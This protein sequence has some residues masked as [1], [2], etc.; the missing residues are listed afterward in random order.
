[1]STEPFKVDIH[2]HMLPR[3]WPDLRQ[4]YGYGGFVHMVRGIW[5]GNFSVD[6][7]R[8]REVGGFDERYRLMYGGEEADLVQR[9]VRRGAL[10][11]WAYNSTAYHL[12]HPTRAYGEVALG[13]VKYKMEHL[14][15]C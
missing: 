14:G 5:G 7:V 1:M 8:F 3:E 4:R 12:A 6:A 10:P 15:T 11:A 2:T 13:N 9:L